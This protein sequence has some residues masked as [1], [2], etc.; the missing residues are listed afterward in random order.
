M[1]SVTGS[2]YVIVRFWI[3]IIILHSSDLPTEASPLPWYFWGIKLV[4]GN[5]IKKQLT[6]EFKKKCM[7]KVEELGFSSNFEQLSS[8]DQGYYKS[9]HDFQPTRLKAPFLVC[10]KQT[11]T[12]S[13]CPN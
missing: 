4:T 1:H 13:S 12:V 10:Y 2:F 11:S 7:Y 5:L 6:Y 3:Q 8:V 9:A